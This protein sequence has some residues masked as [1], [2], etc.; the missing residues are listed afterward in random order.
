ME[1]SGVVI[2]NPV[3]VGEVPAW[4]SGLAGAFLDDPN[5]PSL[6]RWTEVATRTWTSE[7]AWGARDRGRWVATLRT[8]P[9][10]LTV[11]GAA[12]MTGDLAG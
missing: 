5:D 2:V 8:G 3:D 6:D 4:L 9:R 11:P 10:M 7:R 12:G 1:R